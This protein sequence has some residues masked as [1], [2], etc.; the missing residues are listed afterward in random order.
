MFRDYVILFFVIIF[1]T[2]N[3]CYIFKMFSCGLLISFDDIVDTFEK[4]TLRPS[5]WTCLLF[6]TI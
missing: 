3:R 4:N 2:E 1:V 6:C 5:L